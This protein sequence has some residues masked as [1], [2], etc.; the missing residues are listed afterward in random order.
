MLR[1]ATRLYSTLALV[2]C[3]VVAGAVA[4][5]PR[6]RA[7]TGKFEPHSNTRILG[8][9]VAQL[10]VNSVVDEPD[11]FVAIV[12]ADIDADGDLDVVAS[13]SSLQLHIWV[14]D[15]S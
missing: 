4:H 7:S 15:G 3:A 9:A 11:R 12:A 1:S 5:G 8:G 2:V 6:P 10:A 14:N 13:D